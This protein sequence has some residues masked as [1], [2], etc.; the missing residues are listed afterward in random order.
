MGWMTRME[1]ACRLPGL[2]L[3]GTLSYDFDG[4]PLM[5]VR[6]SESRRANLLRCGLDAVL[7]GSGRLGLPPVLQVEPTNVCDLRCPLCPTGDGSMRRA[8]RSMGQRPAF[9]AG[10]PYEERPRGGSVLGSAEFHGPAV[11]SATAQ[12]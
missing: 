11:V 7:D 2:V 1:A 10:C 9:C 6:L 12:A 3:R 5:L 8:V 4:V